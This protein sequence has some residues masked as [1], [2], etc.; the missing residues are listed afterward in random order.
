MSTPDAP[1]PL[2]PPRPPAAR[3]T[4]A[5]VARQAGVSKATVSRFLNRR[6]ELLTRD[7]A[8][9]VEA[10]IATLR[11]TPSP[12][13]QALKRGRSRLI[14]LV[15]A[16][17]TNPY[18]VAV[19]R[20][21]EKACQDAG[22]LVMLFN[23]GNDKGREREAIEA[24]SSYQVEGFILNRVGDDS[25]A[26]A[27][28]VRCGKPVVMVDRRHG[29]L[30]SDFVS[31]DN[32]AAIHLGAR[33]L[34]EAGYGELLFVSEPVQGVSSRLE[35]Q[36]AFCAF[37][38][39][40]WPGAACH[41]HESTEADPQALD[42]ALRALRRRAGGRPPAVLSGNAVITLRLV[43]AAAR[44]GWR[45][46]FDIGLVGFDDTDWAP[47]VGPGLSAIAQPT[48]DLGRLAAECVLARLQGADHA[49]RDILL[50]GRLVVRGSSRPGV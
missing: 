5:D 12:M 45:L 41:T 28:A 25:G 4:I 37:V 49:P 31:L 35:R 36:Q 38:S 39:E 29:D 13:A 26:V 17:I 47:F 43:A 14:G 21:A 3:T 27:E 1:L 18:S 11:Y 10:A 8:A 40:Q 32:A 6:D 22:Y 33:H 50:P 46:G 16:D 9:R 44:L 48:D 7:I 15:V 34:V 2:T 19:L 24:L 30:R 23:L 42:Q 20:G